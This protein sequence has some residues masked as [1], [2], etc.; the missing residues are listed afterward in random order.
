MRLCFELYERSFL[1]TLSDYINR[2]K[3]KHEDLII[4]NALTKI[5]NEM[6]GANMI[7]RHQVGLTYCKIW[8]PFV[9]SSYILKN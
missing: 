4:R 8:L 2:E 1:F 6:S 7:K 3:T 9:F 5:E